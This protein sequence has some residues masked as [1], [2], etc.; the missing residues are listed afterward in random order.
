[1]AFTQ[2]RHQGTNMRV[3]TAIDFWSELDGGV[4]RRLAERQGEMT[5]AEIVRG[6][7]GPAPT[8]GNRTDLVGDGSRESESSIS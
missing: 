6:R 3:P 7:P 8:P 4:L 2:S 5:P 1:M